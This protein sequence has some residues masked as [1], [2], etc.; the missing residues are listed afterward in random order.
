MNFKVT[1]SE[2]TECA[3]KLSAYI[4]EYEAAA[5]A[6]NG[7]ASAL[8]GMWEGD[9]KVAFEAEQEKNVAWMKR[10]VSVCEGYVEALNAAAIAYEAME[11]A[12]RSAIG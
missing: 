7:A 1:P 11:A 10:M 2:L 6:T 4:S 3:S 12:V 9:A 8:C 5:N